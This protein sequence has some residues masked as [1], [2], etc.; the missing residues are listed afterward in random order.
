MDSKVNSSKKFIYKMRVNLIKIR[1]SNPRYR[2]G[3]KNLNPNNLINL[4]PTNVLRSIAVGII[5]EKTCVPIMK[6]A[7]VMDKIV[8][9][10][11]SACC[12]WRY[13]KKKNA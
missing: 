7:S 9:T 13:A 2:L 12:M 11:N 10:N 4:V 3:L 5:Q 6:K 8:N 1:S